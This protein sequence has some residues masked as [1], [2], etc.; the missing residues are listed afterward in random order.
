[1]ILYCANIMIEIHYFR[2]NNFLTYSK[3]TL[4]KVKTVLTVQSYILIIS[5]VA[6]IFVVVLYF[7]NNA[8]SLELSA[9]Q[10]INE[11]LTIQ[12]LNKNIFVVT[13]AFPWPGNSLLVIDHENA[14]LVDTP[15]DRVATQV[16]LDWIEEHFGELKL[17]AIVTGFHQDNLGG[18]E[19][20]IDNQVAVHGMELTEKLI[21]SQSEKLLQEIQG[22]VRNMEDQKYFHRY[23]DLKLIAPNHTFAL[24]PGETKRLLIG[25]NELVFF[26]P[27]ESHTIDNAVVYLPTHKLLFGGCMIRALRDQQPGY[28]GYANINEWP[29]SVMKVKQKFPDVQTVVPGHG[30]YGG[31]S[32]LDHTINILDDWIDNHKEH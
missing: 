16:L 12:Q 21:S 7:E 10:V 30:Q 5:F 19:V 14:I 11:E 31:S 22:M 9:P 18:N 27:V 8:Q 32:L 28:L 26:Y 29:I 23:R 25:Q 15:Y 3:P 20:L 4:I 6:T 24:N 2:V 1:M 17:T 13:H